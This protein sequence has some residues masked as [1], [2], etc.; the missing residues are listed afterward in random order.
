MITKLQYFSD[1]KWLE[2]KTE[3]FMD[4]YNP[5]TGEVLA[6]APCCTKDE[7]EAAI[8]A[9]A[10]AFPAWSATP[11]MKRV[12][13]LYKVRSLLEE[14]MGELT[15]L[16]CRENGKAWGDAEGEILK[17]LEG[18]E[19][20]ISAPNLMLGESLMNASTGV[21][22]VLYREPIGVFAGIVPFNFPAMIPMGWM[23][24]MCMA[25]GNTMIIKAAS[26]T[27]M[28]SLRIAELYQEAG[29]PSGVL[30]I[31]TCS[32]NEAE[33]FLSHPKVKGIS[34]VGSASVGLHVYSTAA[35]NG[36]RVQALAE[37]KNHALVL[38]DAPIGRTAAGII[39]A[40]FGCAGERC[41]AMPVIVVQESIADELVAAIAE[42]AR[43]LNICPA[44]NK[45]SDMGPIVTS[46]HRN[47]VTRWIEKGVEEGAEVVLDGRGYEVP[48]YEKGFFLGPTILDHVTPD[49]TVGI[50][51]IFGPVL[52]V[53]RVKD[54]EE[55]ITLMN[56]SRLANGSIIFTQNGYY[57]REFTRRT[58]GGMVGV[59]VGIPIPVGV[60]PF[61]GHK[62]S[63]F[64]DLHCL[65]KDG[66]RFYTESKSVTTRWFDEEEKRREKVDS[67]DGTI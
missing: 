13:I 44:Y 67:W 3:K 48:G 29:L 5:S 17:V 21:D 11:V 42:K 41:M 60:F 6:Q 14:H 9:A 39:N 59:N 4:V 46:E 52:C 65:G 2:S 55:G 66:L 15:E 37:A 50:E 64:G 27:P 57:A 7:V 12:Q 54:F 62:G 45:D 51:E 35:A 53:K 16:V 43:G 1:G 20:A 28:S 26:M 19:Q 33:L 8:E 22:T 61:C 32:R 38:E 10:A 56:Q 36:K 25:T 34:F 31:V 47:F 24:P 23:F 63:F 30:N 58:H 40:T 49:M 18:T